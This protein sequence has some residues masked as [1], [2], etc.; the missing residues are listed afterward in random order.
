MIVPDYV[1]P[2]VAWRTWYVVD[3]GLSASLSSV[4]HK[5]QWPQRAPLVATCRR[6]RFAV[7][8]FKRDSHDAP[9]EDCGCGIYGARLDGL[10]DYLPDCFAFAGRDLLP[11]VGRV[12]LWGTVHEH[13]LGWR[14]SHAY[15]QMLYVPATRRDSRAE[16]LVRGLGSYGVPMQTVH[17]TNAD[18]ILAAVT[19]AIAA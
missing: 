10:R 19:T 6:L 14:A 18:E 7:W 11:V 9:A 12:L 5:T 2:V 4:V 17:A 16:R 13:E 8:P 3:G 1:E 15:P